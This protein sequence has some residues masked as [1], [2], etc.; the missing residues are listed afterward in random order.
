MLDFAVP[1]SSDA[2]VIM[3]VAFAPGSKPTPAD[4][5]LTRAAARLAAIVL[6]FEGIP[7]TPENLIPR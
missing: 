7:G 4:L 3:R 1:T 6:E 5:R 2:P